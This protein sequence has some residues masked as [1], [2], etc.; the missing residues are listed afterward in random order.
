MHHDGFTHHNA[1][2]NGINLHYVRQGAGEPLLLVHGWPGFWYEWRLN[3][4]PLAERFDVIAPDMRGYAYSDKPDGAPETAYSDTAFAE[5]IRALLDA[6]AVD[7]VNIV[8]HDFGAIWVQRFARMYPER[9]AKLM[10]FD[11]PYLGIGARWFQFPH[12][13]HTWYQVFHQQP[14]AEAIVGASREATRAYISHFLRA[15]SADPNIWTDE[16]IEAYTDAYAQ[17]GALRGGFNCY[18]ATMR[19]GMQSSGDLVIHAPTT[20]LW[21]TKDSIL[22]Y[23]WTDNLPQ[24]FSNLT[25]KKMD[26]VGHFMMREAPERVNA[27]IVA[28]M[29]Q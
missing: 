28:F 20:V 5:D 7:R 12:N 15:W 17:P 25:L 19:G 24:F 26:G 21:G 16:E 14:M 11:P 13:F 6:L 9:M 29:G 3:I 23:E 27:E 8:S 22:P 18:R 4:G 2:V 1:R 10:L